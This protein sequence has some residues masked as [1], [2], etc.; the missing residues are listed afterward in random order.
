MKH[1]AGLF[2]KLRKGLTEMKKAIILSVLVGAAALGS[3]QPSYLLRVKAKPGQVFKYAM[4]VNNGPSN[5]MGM[6]MAMKVVK[7][8]NSVFTIN[9]TMSNMTMN[10]QAMPLQALEQIKKMLIVTT[11]SA[12]G[13]TLKTEVKGVPGMTSAPGQGSSVPFP[14]G[15]VKVGSSWK[16]TSNVQGQKVETTYK[17]TGIKTVLGK[18]AA[19]IQ[20]TPKGITGFKANGPI[21]FSV[22]L[23]TGFP[24]SMSM[25]GTATQGGQSQPIKI[26]MSRL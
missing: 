16:G 9:T 13:D 15:P 3:A 14:A 23:A 11:M 25:N 20:A 1:T 18:Q 17:L 19:V 7:V 24:L 5:K 22:E 10:G 21:V 8:Q 26:T 12:R 4:T 6:N 2:G